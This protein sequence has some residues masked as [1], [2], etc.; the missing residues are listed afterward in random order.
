MTVVLGWWE[1]LIIIKFDKIIPVAFSDK[2]FG[3]IDTSS[4]IK[5]IL[6]VQS[7]SHFNILFSDR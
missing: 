1:I 6:K 4:S 7:L 5:G 2:G 3:H